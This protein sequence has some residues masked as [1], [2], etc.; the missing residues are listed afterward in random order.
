MDRTESN[1][2]FS[3]RDVS[4]PKAQSNGLD[5][6][7]PLQTWVPCHPDI[8]CMLPKIFKYG[9]LAFQF[10][11]TPP[12][13]RFY[14]HPLILSMQYSLCNIAG[15]KLLRPFLKTIFRPL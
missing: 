13:F 15:L 4:D 7:A 6:D 9:E 11:Q 12:S 14:I 5:W 1:R 8:I 10:L 3:E 2:A